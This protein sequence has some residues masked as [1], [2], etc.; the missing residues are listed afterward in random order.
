[1]QRQALRGFSLIE[2]LTVIA[3]I[4]V[5]ATVIVVSLSAARS[6]GIDAATKENLNTI[7]NQAELRHSNLGSYG[8]Q[9]AVQSTAITAAPAY[10]AAGIN[11]FISDQQAN[12]AL[13]AA[14][15][16]GDSGYYAVGVNGQSWAVAIETK[17]VTGYWC[18]DS[19]G[20]GKVITS[21][22]L[23]GGTAAAVCP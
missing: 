7:R 20:T 22:A 17:S 21:T 3:I 10:N 6:K 18:V 16:D 23:G 9:V 4:G 5:L 13:A 2:L 19:Q 12:R 11:F 8:Q 1:M 14:L 15:A